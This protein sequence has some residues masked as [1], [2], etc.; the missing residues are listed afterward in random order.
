MPL[1][2]KFIAEELKIDVALIGTLSMFSCSTFPF[3]SSYLKEIFPKEIL[4]ALHSYVNSIGLIGGILLSG[5]STYIIEKLS[6]GIL[7]IT[8]F[9]LMVLMTIVFAIIVRRSKNEKIEA[10]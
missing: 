5:A 2:S 8:F 9:V 10:K 7:E 1:P 4:P 3:L 6:I